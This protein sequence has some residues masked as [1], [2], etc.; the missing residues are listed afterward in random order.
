MATASGALEV[1]LAAGLR[2]RHKL[3]TRRRLEQAALELFAE[4]GFDATTVEDIAERAEVSPRTFF[5]YF[6][7]KDEVFF[8]ER[9][10][11]LDLL[12]A[13]LGERPPDE[14]DLVAARAA[15]LAVTPTIEEDRP[16]M[17]L[18][19]RAARSTPV[20]RGHLYD[21]VLEWEETL[22]EGLA[23]RR[24]TTPRADQQAR[25]AAAVAMGAFRLALAGWLQEPAVGDLETLLDQRFAA[26]EEL[27]FPVRS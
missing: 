5:R 3:R 25:L 9:A 17:S 13:A 23:A 11:R 22:A 2:E 7:S 19:A 6:T 20:L 18:R 16:A 4:A 21:V 1:S 15:L 27:R 10:W 26:L 24:A 14:P 8:V 12:A